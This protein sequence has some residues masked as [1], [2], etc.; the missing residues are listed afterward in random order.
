VSIIIDTNE[1][2]VANLIMYDSGANRYLKKYRDTDP[3]PW[4]EWISDEE[5]CEQEM[6]LSS[7]H[8]RFYTSPRGKIRGVKVYTKDEETSQNYYLRVNLFTHEVTLE[9][10]EAYLNVSV[11]SDK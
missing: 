2:S 3:D 6:I 8:S 1:P 5:E 9:C 4:V 11:S 7:T 10:E